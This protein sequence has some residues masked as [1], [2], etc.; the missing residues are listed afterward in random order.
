[1]LGLFGAALGTMLI[2]TK[3]DT[4]RANEERE[5]LKSYAESALEGLAILEGDRII[6]ANTVF[7][8]MVRMDPAGTLG[9]LLGAILPQEWSV[10]RAA[11]RRFHRNRAS[12]GRWFPRARG[13]CPPR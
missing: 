6:D 2:D 8:S 1:M 5:H 13:S 4:K 11:R 9:P 10:P 7:W 3:L 12:S